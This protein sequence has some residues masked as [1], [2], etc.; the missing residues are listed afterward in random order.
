MFP[1][2]LS[3]LLQHREESVAEEIRRRSKPIIGDFLLLLDRFGLEDLY[4]KLYTIMYIY[5]DR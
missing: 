2:F 3:Q 1:K 4:T 5:R